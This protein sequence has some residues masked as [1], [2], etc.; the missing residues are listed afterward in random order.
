MNRATIS[1]IIT[2][3]IVEKEIS[4]ENFRSIKKIVKFQ[5]TT[6]RYWNDSFEELGCKKDTHQIVA[7]GDRA[8]FLKARCRP[9]MPVNVSGT[10]Q[11]RVQ[12]NGKT[13]T[14]IFS[15]ELDWGPFSQQL[16]PAVG[17]NPKV[18]QTDDNYSFND[19]AMY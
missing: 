4:F 17:L 10:L 19:F 5:V 16:Q 6:E 7:F 8:L 2:S 18:Q 3:E 15:K 9:G 11:N 12:T 13:V 1:G 14:E